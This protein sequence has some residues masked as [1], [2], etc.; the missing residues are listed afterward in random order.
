MENKSLEILLYGMYLY[1]F[2]SQGI[3][4]YPKMQMCML[5]E[6]GIDLYKN[7]NKLSNEDVKHLINFMVYLG[8]RQTLKES[9]TNTS[10]LYKHNFTIPYIKELDKP[11]IFEFTYYIYAYK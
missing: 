4:Q 8:L 1:H 9:V 5:I 7:E 3:S 11:I 10:Y 2:H 6:Q